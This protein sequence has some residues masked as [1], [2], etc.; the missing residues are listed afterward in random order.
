[1]P[2]RQVFISFDYDRDVLRVAQVRN[3]GTLEGNTLIS[4]NEW[5]QIK[6]GG[7]AAIK[8][9]ID[10]NMQNR[11]CL[12]VLIGEKTHESRWVRYEIQKAWND[13][14]GIVGIYIHNLK[15]PRNGICNQGYN[16]FRDIKMDP[17]TKKVDFSF[18]TSL[19]GIPLSNAIKCFNP[20]WYDAYGDIE[21]HL[22]SLVEEAIHARQ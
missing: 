19:Y 7:D 8:N 3:M 9:W 5:E 4:S 11:S 2:K 20:N 15:C 10:T 18:A 21:N 17:Q 22:E 12:I 1:M 13:G 6:K 14:K 16:L